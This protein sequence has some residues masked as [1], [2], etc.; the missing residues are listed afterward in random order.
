[1]IM[2]T[3]TIKKQKQFCEHLDT[4]RIRHGIA[5]IAWYS[6]KKDP[7]VLMMVND[8]DIRYYITIISH[9]QPSLFTHFLLPSN[10]SVIRRAIGLLL[11]Q[12]NQPIERNAATQVN[13][14]CCACSK[15]LIRAVSSVVNRMKTPWH[16]KVMCGLALSMLYALQLPP[17][18]VTHP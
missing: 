6:Y 3:F 11:L 2:V 7:R 10:A 16:Q 18:C 4:I 14:G 12:V 17:D 15:E 9:H 8:I 13:L 5:G 1:M